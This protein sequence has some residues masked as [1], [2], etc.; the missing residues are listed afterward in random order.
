MLILWSSD[1]A[2]LLLLLLCALPTNICFAIQSLR[3]R[4]AHVLVSLLSN[5]TVVKCKQMPKVA[6]T[7]KHSI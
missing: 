7:Q 3:Q 2:Q 6:N 5:E 1:E 4:N